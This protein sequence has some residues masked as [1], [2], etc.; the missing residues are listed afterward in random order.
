[1]SDDRPPARTG[2]PPAPPDGPGSPPPVV[3]VLGIG[4]GP[5]NLALAIA[6]EEHN[7]A[8]PPDGR[9]QAAAPPTGHLI[10]VR[11]DR[12]SMIS[13]IPSP[14]GRSLP[15]FR[16]ACLQLLRASRLRFPI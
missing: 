6:V 3:D 2:A 1:M 10:Q 7:A 11:A 12:L 15:R 9:L 5:S 14:S 13:Q 16:T 4:F 8:A